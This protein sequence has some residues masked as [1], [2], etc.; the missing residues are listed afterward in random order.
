MKPLPD[1]IIAAPIAD[2][3][4]RVEE[5]KTALRDALIT[6]QA[7]C[8]HRIVSEMPYQS[9]SIAAHRICNHCRFIERGSHWSGGSVWSKHDHSKSDLDNVTGRLVLPVTSDQ[10]WKMRVDC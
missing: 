4:A 7:V 2:A 9:G 3:I 8:E 1:S 5:A 10:F 6:V